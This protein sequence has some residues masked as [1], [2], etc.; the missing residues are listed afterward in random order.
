M[1]AQ[2]LDTRFQH[3]KKPKYKIRTIF[4]FKMPA[5]TTSVCFMLL[6]SVFSGSVAAV[7]EP[8]TTAGATDLAGLAQQLYVSRTS[9]LLI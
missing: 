6:A 9:I 8:Q 7:A 5:K 3:T 1:R 4:T 2:V